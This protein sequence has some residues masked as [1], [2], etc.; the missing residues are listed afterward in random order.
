MRGLHR[1]DDGEGRRIRASADPAVIFTVAAVVSTAGSV[2]STVAAVETQAGS[3]A[4]E[5]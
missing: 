5:V 3:A 4:W 2:L 1:R